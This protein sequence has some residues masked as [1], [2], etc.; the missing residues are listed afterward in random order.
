MNPWDLFS[1]T[2]KKKIIWSLSKIDWRKKYAAKP[3]AAWNFWKFCYDYT[4]IK[5][6]VIQGRGLFLSCSNKK[7]DD[8]CRGF[9]SGKISCSNEEETIR[10]DFFISCQYKVKSYESKWWY[11]NKSSYPVKMPDLNK[12]LVQCC[13]H[14]SIILCK[15][16]QQ[17]CLISENSAS[18]SSG[19]DQS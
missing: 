18:K 19:I 10:M 15:E 11:S 16:Y 2:A 6:L 17:T 13:S 5:Q 12:I 8:V 4:S 7:K 1:E 14:L 3:Y 9:D